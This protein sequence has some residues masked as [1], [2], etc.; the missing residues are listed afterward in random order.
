MRHLVIAF[1]LLLPGLQA[2]AASPYAGEESRA[3]KAMSPEDVAAYLEGRGMGFAKPAE[4]N[5]YPGP[6]HVLELADGLALTDAQRESSRA[7]MDRHKAEVRAL[8]REYIVAEAAVERLFARGE[9]EAAAVDAAVARAAALQARIRTAH[10]VTHLAQARILSPEQVRSYA[11]LR[12]YGAPKAAPDGG[13][14]HA[15]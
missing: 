7:L 8:G 1:V 5:G 15:H 4:L 14:R 6:M 12:G 10:L 9:A 2:G 13:H 11:Q 3:L